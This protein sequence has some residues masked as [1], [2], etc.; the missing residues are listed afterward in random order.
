MVKKVLLLVIVAASVLVGLAGALVGVYWGAFRTN[1][2]AVPENISPGVA[3]RQDGLVGP[4]AELDKALALKQA[5]TFCLTQP[6]TTQD[7]V[8]TVLK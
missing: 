7:M 2:H 5:T 6:K 3:V 8:L 1:T 4:H